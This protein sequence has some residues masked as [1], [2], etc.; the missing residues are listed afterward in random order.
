MTCDRFHV[1]GIVGTVFALPQHSPTVAQD[2]DPHKLL[3]GADRL[4]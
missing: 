1:V 3:A 2:S 4:A